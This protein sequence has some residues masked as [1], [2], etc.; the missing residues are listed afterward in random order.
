MIFLPYHMYVWELSRENEKFP[1][2]GGYSS[3]NDKSCEISI[4]EID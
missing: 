1:R 2:H 4:V 3:R